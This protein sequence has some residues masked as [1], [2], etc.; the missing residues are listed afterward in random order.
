MKI[1][2]NIKMSDVAKKANVSTATVSRVLSNPAVVKEETRRKVMEVIEELQYRPHVIARQFRTQE[3]KMVLVVVPDITS[4]FFSEVLRGIEHA[5]VSRNYQVVLGDSENNLEREKQYVDLLYQKQVD[6]VILLT[7]KL[8]KEMLEQ[9]ASEFPIVL[10]CEYYDGID[11]PTVSIDNIGS[12]RKA[13]EHLVHLGHKRIGHISGPAGIILSR[14]RL[15]GYKEA[16]QNNGLLVDEAYIAEGPLTIESGY[17]RMKMLLSLDNPPTAVFVYNDEMAWGAI[18]AVKDHGLRI[19]EDIAVVGFDNLK[20]SEVVEPHLS[21][22]EQPK[23]LIGKKSMELLLQLIHGKPLEK[24]N[25][26]LN[27][28]LIVRHSSVLMN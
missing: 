9:L 13:T 15:Q 8:P 4:I 24:K 16:L 6:G 26:V 5:A 11:V 1:D 14:D 7:A 23:Y 10:A 27:S 28:S 12:A 25:Y 18:K 17:R 2:Q 3:T 22:I 19:P 21:T 20:I